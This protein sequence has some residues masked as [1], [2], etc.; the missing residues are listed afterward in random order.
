MQV[1]FDSNGSVRPCVPSSG[2]IQHPLSSSSEYRSC[3]Q[4]QQ[5]SLSLKA[6]LSKNP[7]RFPPLN[8]APEPVFSHRCFPP[9]PPSAASL[10]HPRSARLFSRYHPIM[11]KR[12]Y[13][14]STDGGLPYDLDDAPPSRSTPV[15]SN[16][17]SSTSSSIQGTHQARAD[18]PPSR[19]PP[20]DWRAA[21][22]DDEDVDPRDDDRRSESLKG[23]REQH[24][25]RDAGGSRRTIDRER[26]RERYDPREDRSRTDHT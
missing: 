9:F 15:N 4:Q 17:P 23:E 20:R 19:A 26:G 6:C 7:L 16:G 5:F 24:G 14:D 22:L 25:R 1:Q 21:F 2:T 11:S 10:P 13:P 8:A 12:S 18:R 3:Q